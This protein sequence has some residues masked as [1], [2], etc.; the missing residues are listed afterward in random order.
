MRALLGWTPTYTYTPLPGGGFR[1]TQDES[2]WDFTERN[3]AL[4]LDEI[5]AQTCPGCGGDLS[6]ELT[7]KH[8]SEDDGDGHYH[9]ATALWCRRCVSQAKLRRRTEKEDEA[10]AGSVADNFPAARRYAW[11]RLPIPTR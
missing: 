1:I 9:K 2:E 7:N 3:L 6:V 4:A 8:P 11:E 5:D 10:L